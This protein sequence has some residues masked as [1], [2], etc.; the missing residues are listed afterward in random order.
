MR[1]L[2]IDAIRNFLITRIGD[3][4]HEAIELIGLIAVR[5]FGCSE[6][7]N[8]SFSVRMSKAVAGFGLVRARKRRVVAPWEV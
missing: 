6:V 4:I 5:S 7:G 1:E 2:T 3:T 8:E